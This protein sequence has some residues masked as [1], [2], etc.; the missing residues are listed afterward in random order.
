MDL[1]NYVRSLQPDII[2]N[3]RVGKG[4]S[5]MAGMDKGGERVGDYGTPE[6]EIPPT[7]FGP[8]VDWESCMTMNNHW[9]YNKNDQNWKSSTTLI[10]NLIDCAS[11][12]GNYL[13]N[14]GPTAEGVFPGAS[15][16]RLQD[17]GKWMKVNSEAI[18]GTQASPF[19]KLAWGRCTQK[20]LAGAAP[21]TGF[22]QHAAW[23]FEDLRGKLGTAGTRLYL[24]V[25][26][27]PANGQLVIPGLANKPRAR[28]PARR[29]RG[30]CRSPPRTTRVTISRA[31]R[32][33]GQDRL[34]RRARHPGRAADR[35]ARPL[36]RRDARP[37]RRAHGV[38]AR[39]P[40]R[41][42]HSLGRLFRPRRHLQG[43]ADRRHR[44]VDHEPRQDSHGRIPRST[45]RSSTR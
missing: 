35:Q 19:E 28:V 21:S 32:R 10:R 42:V 24:F 26:D 6:Q 8:G 5:G 15:I 12:G 3:N 18:Y 43:Q 34:G 9:G 13:L 20:Q 23:P 41:H 14:I 2:I 31:R 16:E 39:G 38:V 33:A 17:I 22:Q 36:C 11:K 30:R 27:W 44:R 1:Y 40:L 25:Y 29:R 4:R 37:A 45:P 7:G